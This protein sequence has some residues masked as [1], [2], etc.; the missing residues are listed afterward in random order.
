MKELPAAPKALAEIFIEPLEPSDLVTFILIRH[1]KDRYRALINIGNE[2][3]G[4]F[5]RRIDYSLSG[6]SAIFFG[7]HEPRA[8]RQQ[9]GRRDGT[10]FFRIAGRAS[11]QFRH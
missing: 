11:V 7:G 10:L 5:P 8:E 1:A 2:P 3:R 6:R 9:F 4:S